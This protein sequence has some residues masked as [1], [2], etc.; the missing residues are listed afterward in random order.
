M[1]SRL[2]LSAANRIRRF[3]KRFEKRLRRPRHRS[4]SGF[5]PGS[6]G[7]CL[8]EALD[9]RQI[10]Y[11]YLRKREI[12]RARETMDSRALTPVVSFSIGGEP[13][14]FDIGLCQPER[15]ITPG[16]FVPSDSAKKF[17]RDKVLVKTL[18]HANGFSVPDGAAFARED[19][20]SAEAFFADFVSERPQGVCI[21]P[22]H[23][24]CGKHVYLGIRDSS[25]FHDAWKR[26]GTKIDH[27]LIEEMVLGSMH[28]VFCLGGRAIA[29]ISWRT[30]NVVG[31]GRHTIEGLIERKNA[32]RKLNPAYADFPLGLGQEE[33]RFLCRAGL[34]RTYVPAQDQ[35]IY[36]R[37][38]PNED[39]A[40][41]TTDTLHAS[42]F[43]LVERALA[44]LPPMAYCGA[45][46]II[47][48]ASAPAANDNHCFLEFNYP[49]RFVDHHHPWRGRSRDVAGAILDYL[50]EAS[51]VRHPA[52]IGAKAEICAS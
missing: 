5:V 9:A 19:L 48:D 37:P 14:D 1:P 21:K 13:Y 6:C 7:Y 39:E 29:A 23:G 17:T 22:R 51:Q 16:S 18:L 49:A 45:D 3:A 32:E 2:V 50:S 12:L 30:M 4:L 43:R 27:V 24:W 10:P 35:V 15:R 28:R 47:E 52:A 11:R 8:V 20:K 31:D 38:P 34:D 33:L 25:S 42:Y 26:I 46:L 44:V 36:L 40:I 41:D